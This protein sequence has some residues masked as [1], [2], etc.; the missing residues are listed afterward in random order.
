MSA[1]RRNRDYLIA[2]LIRWWTAGAVYFFLGWGTRLGTRESSFDLVFFLGLTIGALNS[3]VV[4]PVIQMTFG[5]GNAKPYREM[6]TAGR[7]WRR[8]ATVMQALGVVVLVTLLYQGINV[9]ATH[10]FTLDEGQ[11]FLP[12]EPIL[13]GLFYAG[14]ASAIRVLV[15]RLRPGGD[16]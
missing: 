1:G 16:R 6:T 11:V 7:V 4:D 3:L 12:G 14:L 9:A 8:L 10:L 5:I 15:A 2:F 13:F